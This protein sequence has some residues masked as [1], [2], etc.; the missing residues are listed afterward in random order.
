[1]T[2][3]YRIQDEP[4]A[5]RSSVLIFNPFWPLLALMLAGA[6]LG[7][8]MFAASAMCLRGQTWRREVLLAAAIPIGACILTLIVAIAGTAADLPKL[9]IS[10]GLLLVTAWKLGVGYWIFFLQQNA[11]SLYEY[12]RGDVSAGQSIPLGAALVTFGA[13]ARAHVVDAVPSVYWALAI[14]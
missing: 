8:L 4:A 7:V 9:A 13:L 12:F 6:W 10:Y 1:V 14:S 11:F 2:T 3:T 5:S